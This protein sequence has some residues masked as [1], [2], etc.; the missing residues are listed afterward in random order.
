MAEPLLL[1]NCQWGW[2]ERGLLLLIPPPAPPSVVH[3]SMLLADLPQQY[4][5]VP[6]PGEP[7]CSCGTD[8][9]VAAMKGPWQ[10]YPLLQE[11]K[12]KWEIQLEMLLSFQNKIYLGQ[13]PQPVCSIYG[14]KEL[15]AE[16]L[17]SSPVDFS[18]TIKEWM[19]HLYW[20]VEEMFILILSQ[21]FFFLSIFQENKTFSVVI[22]LISVK[23]SATF[24]EWPTV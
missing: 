8:C 22:V 15:T 3:W 6:V 12:A 1:L 14:N 18:S 5:P 7:L 2:P 23:Y 9:P 16:S 19:R 4:F 21:S 20:R 24:S 17:N 13:S 10:F 11:Q